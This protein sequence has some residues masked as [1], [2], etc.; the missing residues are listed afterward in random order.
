MIK[1]TGC[2]FVGESLMFMGLMAVFAGSDDLCRVFVGHEGRLGKKEA[3]IAA[4]HFCMA[5]MVWK[6]LFEASFLFLS[7]SCSAASVIN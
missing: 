7:I 5:L 4:L 1:S 3:A 6:I 2:L